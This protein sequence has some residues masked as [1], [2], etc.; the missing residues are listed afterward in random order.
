[1]ADQ[2]KRLYSV[3]ISALGGE[4]GGVLSKWF[5]DLAESQGQSVQ[6]TYIP[7]VA[8]RTGA[9]TYYIEMCP[10]A[11]PAPQGPRRVRALMPCP[12]DVDLLLA[13][14]ILE[15]GRA[16]Q[17][18]Y[19]TRERTEVIGSTHRIYAVVEKAAMG[20]GRVQ[21]EQIVEALR[22][23]A[24]R[25]VGFD[26]AACAR[27]S[28]AGESG[29]AINAVLFGAL[30]GSGI[31]PFPKDAYEAA[32]RGGAVAVDDNLAGFEL[33]YVIAKGGD[34]P[35]RTSRPAA[36]AETKA[37]PSVAVLAGRM[38]N[39]Y[40]P[41]LHDILRHGIVKL[42]DYQGAAY[43]QRYLERLD[44][45]LKLDSAAGGGERGFALTRESARWLARLMAY[46]DIIR[47]ADLKT[48]AS[49]FERV[50]DEV[51]AGARQIV[52]VTDFL[53]PSMAEFASIVPAPLA[54]LL[55]GFSE[56]TGFAAKGFPLSLK[57]TSVFGFML[58][59]AAAK[60]KFLRPRSDRFRREQQAIDTW[61]AALAAAA[62]RDY[63][64]ALEV[65]ACAR[66]VKG[67]GPT[68]CRGAQNFE[69]V[70]RHIDAP[71]AVRTIR[72]LRQAA[73]ADDEGKA[74]RGQLARPSG[75]PGGAA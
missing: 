3:L 25:F 55:L 4:G 44:G 23:H 8:Q 14:E 19:V 30:A 62:G 42:A 51:K 20:D 34:G 26:M 57:T 58:M 28:R 63:D 39:A 2:A 18:G 22:A 12:G 65:A 35:A 72:A 1:M 37:A 46:D 17:T 73:L 31:L 15:A 74:L 52:R 48:R 11:E 41:A 24:K 38:E 54:R 59:R 36:T 50:N 47:V 9:T 13:T 29:G 66:L 49:R 69:T 64:L 53:K 33:G 7:G 16:L 75:A 6:Y 32:I 70:L 10:R 40:P 60:L 21:H 27:A 45:I 71:D 61:L 68:H 67:Y 43:A 56:R 5:V